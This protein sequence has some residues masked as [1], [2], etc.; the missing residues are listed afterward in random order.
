MNFN[1]RCNFEL[2][3]CVGVFGLIYMR[4]DWMQWMKDREMPQKHKCEESRNDLNYDGKMYVTS[5]L[6]QDLR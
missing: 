1:S 5:I 2:S 3:K 6:K 4:H